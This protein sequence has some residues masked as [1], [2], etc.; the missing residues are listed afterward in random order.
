MSWLA[1]GGGLIFFVVNVV[2]HF[3]TVTIPGW[4]GGSGW[5]AARIDHISIDWGT[6]II[7]MGGGL[8]EPSGGADGFN[9]G[10]FVFL[11]EGA[12]GDAGLVR[13]ETGH[14]LNVAAFGALFHF[15]GALDENWP[16]NRGDDA[17]AERLAESHSNRPGSPTVPLWG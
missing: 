7:V 11:R 6:G 2:M 3:F 4:F 13:H 17:F 14:G 16:S 12:S 10:N 1:T 8:I 15:V 5:D 9:L